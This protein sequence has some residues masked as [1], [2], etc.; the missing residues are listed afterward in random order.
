MFSV[1]LKQLKKG[2]KKSVILNHL[3]CYLS[4]AIKVAK[5]YTI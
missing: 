5:S 4:Y 2:E 3:Y 1:Y